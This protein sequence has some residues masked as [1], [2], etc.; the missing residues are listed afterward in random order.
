MSNKK[1]IKSHNSL[2][3]QKKYLKTIYGGRDG[4]AVVVT[5][6][7]YAQTPDTIKKG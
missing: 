3:L 5:K 6:K 2:L 4:G 7:A 1:S